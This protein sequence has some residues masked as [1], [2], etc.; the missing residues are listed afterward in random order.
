MS[1]C[2]QLYLMKSDLCPSLSFCWMTGEDIQREGE[3][4][5][6]KINSVSN[7]EV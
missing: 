5:Q 1:S 7:S 3:V 2:R 6:R 4:Y